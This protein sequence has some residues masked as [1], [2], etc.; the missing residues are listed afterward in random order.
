MTASMQG[1]PNA[2]SRGADTGASRVY[3]DWEYGER[4][5]EDAGNGERLARGLGWFSLGLGL[6]QIANPRG[7]A[8][9]IGLRGNDEH[10]NAMVAIGMREIA[11]G[12][13]IL[14]Q[15]RPTGA[16]WSRVG[17]DVMDLALLGRA[18]R[19]E[20]NDRNRVAAA[21]VAVVG[22]TVIDCWQRSGSGARPRPTA[23][24]RESCESAAST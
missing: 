19:S 7:V 20:R 15:H 18:L 4:N 12:I 13:G 17:G 22:A 3:R 2:G 16:V 5:Q 11:S 1:R 9:M 21:T 14:M 10:R 24:R 8:R 6:T 23:A